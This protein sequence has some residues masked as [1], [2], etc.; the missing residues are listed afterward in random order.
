MPITP[1]ENIGSSRRT[2]V[3]K[4]RAICAALGVDPALELIKIAQNTSSEKLKRD[5]YKD[6]LE[7]CHPKLRHMQMDDGNGNALSPV[8]IR[9]KPAL[10]EP[11][12]I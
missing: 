11:E 3:M 4:V 2:E 5:I 8:V 9:I 6:L 10:P 7:Y 1:T 12:A